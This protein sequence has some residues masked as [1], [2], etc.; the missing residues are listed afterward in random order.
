MVCFFAAWMK[1][2]DVLYRSKESPDLNIM[3]ESPPQ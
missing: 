2:T 1:A 3:A